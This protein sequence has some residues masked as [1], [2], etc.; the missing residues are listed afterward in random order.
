M[1]FKRQP[2]AIRAAVDNDL[3]DVLRLWRE[4]EVTPPGPTDSLEGLTR[5]IHDPAGIL[6]V[7]IVE[8]RIVGSLIGG[9]DGWRGNIYRLAVIPA[10]RR[11]GVGGQLVAEVCNS[12][13]A[14]GAERISALV[15]HEHG[16]ATDFWDSL[17]GLGFQRDPKFFRY[18]ADRDRS[19]R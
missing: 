1:G 9:W 17:V 15:E 3:P 7:A 16:W 2:A 19:D 5:L 18:I 4:A 12:L 11:R 8:G 10:Y 14:K 13:F 6:L